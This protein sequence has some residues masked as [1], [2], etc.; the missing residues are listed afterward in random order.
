M[1]KNTIFL[2][3]LSLCLG[4]ISLQAQQAPN[5]IIV[6]TDD[7][8][9]NDLSCEGNPYIK[10]PNIDQF[11]SEAVRLTDFH[12]STTCAPSRGALLTGRH[13]N[14]LNV[15]HTIAG[16]SILFEDEVLLPEILAANG[17][18]NG[19]FGKWHLGD[20]YPYRPMDRGFHE[21]VRH[22]GG[23]ITQGPDFWG[24]DYFDDTYWHNGQ[25]Q[26]YEG[27]CTDVFFDEALDF[28][29][30]NKDQPF[31]CYI[32]TN[33]PHGPLNVPEEYMDL[34]KDESVLS[35]G[36]KRFYGMIT[37][38]DDNFSRLRNKL[39]ELEISDNTILIF[40]TDNGTAGGNR[41]YDAGMS[42]HKG[43]VMEGGHRLPFYIKW[44]ARGIEG[45]KEVNQLTAHF[46]VL[47]TLVELA[48]LKFTPQKTL[49]GQSLRPLL[50]G[51]GADTW[52]NRLLYVDTQR[53]L[54]LTKYKDYSVMDQ[55]WRLVNGD[56]LYHMP[57]DLKQEKN[58]IAEHPEVAERMAL[59]YEKWWESIMNEENTGDYAYIK[60][61]TAYE[62]PSRIAAHD[63]L[64]GDLKRGWHQFGAIK[65]ETASGFWKLEFVSGGTYKIS[66]R[67]FPRESGLGI[68]ETFA[69]QQADRRIEQLAPASTKSDF[70][71][72]YLSLAGFKKNSPITAGAEEVS[73]EME[74]SEGKYDVEA[75]LID[76][77]GRY[78]P[79]FYMYV[80]KK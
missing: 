58:V 9:K 8:G 12:V 24:N 5:I 64:T 7:Q 25:P 47:P 26:A 34:Y 43:S 72:A 57:S 68:N 30:K 60:V 74:I 36:T 70:A 22:G 73:F 16:R 28:I 11:Y 53:V 54:D 37:N 21:V 13:T 51:N 62:N 56:Q 39:E 79:A 19:H 61:G 27:Y 41:V 40:M 1:R 50:E 18:T 67:R 59:G 3:I 49:D 10:T 38:I 65:P 35:E 44:P 33:A 2:L 23:G 63:L 17:Y 75:R 69:A 52:P 4:S 42:G 55:N 48:D 15:H 77:L 80:E 78:Y 31:F 20:N 29:D 71:E 76:E 6:I 14:R 66:L 46:D 45:G 32:S